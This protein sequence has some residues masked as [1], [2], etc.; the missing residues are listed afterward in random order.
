MWH[1]Y[2][3][4]PEAPQ[5][6]FSLLFQEAIECVREMI[7]PGRMNV[8]VRESVVHTLYKSTLDRVCLG[9]L[10]RDLSKQQLLTE[11][12]FIVG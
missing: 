9:Q 2:L 1:A 5:S 6:V 3:Y 10:F 7:P 4:Q 11:E 12:A 8:F